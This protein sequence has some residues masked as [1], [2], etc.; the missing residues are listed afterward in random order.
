MANIALVSLPRQDL[1]RPPAAI[2]ILGA[3]CEEIEIDYDF[4]DLNLWLHDH[5]E[6]HQWQILDDNWMKFDSRF[7]LQSDLYLLF[8]QQ[9]DAFVTNMTR[10]S[11]SMIAVSVFTRWSAHCALELIARLQTYKQKTG[12]KLVIGGTGISTV[13]PWKSD[14]PLCVWLL[15][16]GQIDYFLDGEGEITFRGLLSH[17]TDLPG[18]NNFDYHQ[19]D[20]LDAFPYPSYR[21]IDVRRY[22]YLERPSLSINGSR[23]C[24]RKC[25][26]CDVAKYWPKFRYK[27]G[28]SL[29]EE[30]LH[31]WRTTGIDSFEFSDSLIN[32]NLREFRKMNH[33][34]I[35]LKNQIPGFKINYK[36]QF[37][38]RDPRSF[39][40]K[41]YQD[42][43]NAG[44]DYLYVGVE[45]FS[46]RV[47][48]DMD[49]KFDNV[50]LDFH[51]EMCG[52]YGI[53]NVFLM[54]VG[55][56]TETQADHL[57][58]LEALV[59]YQKYSQAGIIELITWG[60]TTS[61]LPD[62]PLYHQQH[63]LGIVPEFVL[64]DH[65]VPQAWNWISQQN[66]KLGIRERIK[67]WIE[68]TETA[69][70]LGYR[71]TNIDATAG[72]LEQIL[73]TVKNKPYFIPI[74]SKNSEQTL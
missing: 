21:K 24:V 41:D 28:Q 54:L 71:M 7:D 5:M 67:R 8:V 74:L 52:K 45:T 62:T 25:T 33:H 3:A 44:C 31:T 64:G 59:R 61:I 6:Q 51:L 40:E 36:G 35:A 66:P 26:Y 37:I 72:K 10:T 39:T 18:I 65:D 19:I 16:N 22:H 56:P 27:S 32:G 20:D 38:I 30:I 73:T 53:P 69:A 15:D 34:L 4:F 57:Y 29:A 1:L 11:P 68:L 2:A 43:H 13:L 70:D 49:K 63:D 23:G 14:Q 50:S 46:Q 9:L 12:C 17:N 58:N 60:F 42:L 47:R 55:Y 48:Y